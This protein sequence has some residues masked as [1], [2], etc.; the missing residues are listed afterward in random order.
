MKAINDDIFN[1]VFS[2]IPNTAE[3]SFYGMVETVER[4]LNKRKADEIIA[5]N[6]NLTADDINNILSQRPRIEKIAI[7]GCQTKNV[8][9]PRQFKR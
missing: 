7:K 2:Y 8:Y 1:T 9:Y 6:G 3:T 4:I 5:K